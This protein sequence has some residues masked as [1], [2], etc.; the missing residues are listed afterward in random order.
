MTEANNQGAIRRILLA[1]PPGQFDIILED[2]RS[3][4]PKPTLL[5][6][7]FVAVIRSEWDAANGRSAIPAG[8]DAGSECGDV[9]FYINSLSEAMDLHLATNFSSPGVRAAHNVTASTVDE[10]PTLTIATYAERI[11]LQNHRAGSWKGCYKIC[12]TSGSIHGEISVWAHTFEN[13]G[14]VQLI[15]N[16]SLDAT[17]SRCS[18]TDGSEKRSSWSSAVTRQ[19]GSWEEIELMKYHTYESIGSSLKRLRRVMPVT[20]T[21]M[22]WN[23]MAHRVKQTLSEGHDKDKFKH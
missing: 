5:E 9:K 17:L 15:S 11:D 8:G 1:S 21:K 10:T 14:N 20:R 16:I 7:N 18:T 23:V 3:I 6:P 22:E 13:G 12:P 19:I 2:L 4:L